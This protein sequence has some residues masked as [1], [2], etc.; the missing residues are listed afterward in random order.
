MEPW[1]RTRATPA[2]A[3]RFKSE[4]TC[5][6]KGSVACCPHGKKFLGTVPSTY[7]MK[8]DVCEEF[9]SSKNKA[10][11][12]ELCKRLPQGHEKGV[13]GRFGSGSCTGDREGRSPGGRKLH[14]L[15]SSRPKG[16]AQAEPAGY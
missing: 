16:N 14:L 1:A 2:Q 8:F 7:F 12:D 10:R 9:G 5:T 3:P 11:Q 6:G 15:C 13:R 4:A